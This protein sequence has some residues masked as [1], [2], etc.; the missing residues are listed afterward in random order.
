MRGSQKVN[1]IKGFSLVTLRCLSC[2]S[3]GLYQA[4]D[5]MA[6]LHSDVE[7]YDVIRQEYGIDM[8]NNI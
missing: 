4:D 2:N 8:E 1:K 5:F 7:E 6:H 3:D